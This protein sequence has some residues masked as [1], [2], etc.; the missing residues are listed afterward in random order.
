MDPDPQLTFCHVT[1]ETGQH[2][3]QQHTDALSNG[4]NNQNYH[5]LLLNTVTRLVSTAMV[6]SVLGISSRYIFSNLNNKC[7]D[8]KMSTIIKFDIAS[9]LLSHFQCKERELSIS[10]TIGFVSVLMAI[11]WGGAVSYTHLTLPT[12]CCV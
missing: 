10:L 7:H 1:H 11:R 6:I 9:Y 8:P 4:N 12:S 2:R 3:L 5:I